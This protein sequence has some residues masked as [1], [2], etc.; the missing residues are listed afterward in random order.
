MR[1]WHL[2]HIISILPWLVSWRADSKSSCDY[3]LSR[4]NYSISRRTN[5]IPMALITVPV[6][7]ISSC[8]CMEPVLMI[9]VL[10]IITRHSYGRVLLVAVGEHL[11]LVHGM[12]YLQLT[13]ILLP[14]L[15]L[16]KQEPEQSQQR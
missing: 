16:T 2:S 12:H 11:R 14:L 13:L 1:V 7:T 6:P 4:R 5:N 8:L 15:Q 9:C 3:S 10:P